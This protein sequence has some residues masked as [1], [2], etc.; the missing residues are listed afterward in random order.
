LLIDPF[1]LERAAIEEILLN[2]VR[3]SFLPPEEKRE[4]ETEFV[5]ELARLPVA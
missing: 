4:M 3:H 5:A 1:G 2:G